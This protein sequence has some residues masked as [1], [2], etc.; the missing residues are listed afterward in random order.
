MST[1]DR[2]SVVPVPSDAPR[3]FH[4]RYTVQ[5]GHFLQS[6][7]GTDDQTFDFKTQNFG[8]INRSYDTDI[9][10]EPPQWTRFSNHVRVLEHSKKPNESFKVLFLGRHGQ[11]WHNVAEAKYGTKAWDCYWSVLNGTDDITWSDAHLT[12]TGESQALDVNKLWT[13]QL[14]HGI[15]AP[16]TYY[17]SPLTRTIQT[18][19]LS[20]ANL[21]LPAS[22]PY[23]PVIKELLREALGV[24]TCDRRSTKTEIE[25]AFPHLVFEP[26]FSEADLLW[27][28]EYREPI[29][30]RTYRFSML[31]DNIFA[32]DTHV[33]LSLTSH[34]GAIGSIL[35][36][37]GHRAFGLE[38]G[39][40]IPVFVK[41]ERVQGARMVPP[42]EPSDAPP[43]CEEP[44]I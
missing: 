35:E 30:A 18:A 16:E 26:D 37:L 29:S 27:E 32:E 38:T 33:F 11:G 15:P 5:K 43:L 1:S 3:D 17:I 28:A 31:L 22:R 9:D 20:F 39:G 36:V 8:L 42:K 21:S 34:S 23:K 6:E 2:S 7:D 14:P 24:H 19:E 41:A 10:E 44:P 12:T 25:T 13:S 4:F 40:V